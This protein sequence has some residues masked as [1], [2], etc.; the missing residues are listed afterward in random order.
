MALVKKVRNV[1]NSA[2]L[3]LDRPVLQQ[4]GWRVGTPVRIEVQDHRI[5]LTR[6]EPEPPLEL[7]AVSVRRS[8]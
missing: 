5:V 8:R 6:H 7:D 3:I 2:G 1:G 4:A